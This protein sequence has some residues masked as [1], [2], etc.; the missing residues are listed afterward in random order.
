MSSRRGVLNEPSNV[1]IYLVR[2]L[3]GE[4]LEEIGRQCGVSKYS[5]LSSVIQRMKSEISTNR[6][7]RKRVEQLEE[8]LK[9]RQERT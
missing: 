8:E 4:K 7:L 6:K 9:M 1:A 3:R 5:S 2:R